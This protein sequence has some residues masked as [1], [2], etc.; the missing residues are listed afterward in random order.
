MHRSATLN[1]ANEGDFKKAKTQNV[2]LCILRG[3]HPLPLS[4]SPDRWAEALLQ[5]MARLVNP[6]GLCH[7][8]DFRFNRSAPSAA[9]EVRG[10][11]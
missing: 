8:A 6:I 4:E 10:Q 3:C 7:Q 2:P 5:E 1:I 9:V 11:Q